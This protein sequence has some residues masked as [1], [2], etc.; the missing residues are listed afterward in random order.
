[1]T[2]NSRARHYEPSHLLDSFFPEIE[3][4]YEGHNP[5]NRP[6]LEGEGAKRRIVFGY[7]GVKYSL[8]FVSV[9]DAQKPVQDN[10]LF[11]IVHATTPVSKLRQ[12]IGGETDLLHFLR[13]AP[14]GYEFLEDAGIVDYGRD[15][16]IYLTVR[17]KIGEIPVGERGHISGS[18]YK[19]VMKTIIA[20]INRH[21]HPEEYPQ[22][23][24][25]EKRPKRRP[26]RHKPKYLFR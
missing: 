11:V 3:R 23:P 1:M 22:V 16:D 26:N 13:Q 9:S 2:K 25:E 10:G 7:E 19:G 14:E 12:D 8:K 18:L 4:R 15:N 17:R 5:A 6:V 24:R 21:L 20:P